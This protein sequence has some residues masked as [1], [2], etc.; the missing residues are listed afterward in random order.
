MDTHKTEASE[1]V[2]DGVLV[3]EVVL[4]AVVTLVQQPPVFGDEVS[5]WPGGKLLV[6]LVLHVVHQHFNLGVDLHLLLH[7]FG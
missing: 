3:K 5:N 1:E 7:P 6:E 2:L 4:D